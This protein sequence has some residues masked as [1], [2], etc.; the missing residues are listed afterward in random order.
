MPEQHGRSGQPD[1]G[2]SRDFWDK[3][4]A[5]A[6]LAAGVLVA[7]IGGLFTYVYNERA[8]SSQ[9]A[10]RER[11]LNVQH[12]RTV[13]TL[14]PHLSSSD[15]REKEFALVAIS[16]LGNGS[17]AVKLGN[18]YRDEASVGAL[19]KIATGGDQAAARA[20]RRSLSDIL[21][22]MRR[23]VVEVEYGTSRASG[24]I[25]GDGTVVTVG[26]AV[27]DGDEV[28]LTFVDGETEDAAVIRG[29]REFGVVLVQ[30]RGSGRNALP[31]K[32][33]ADVGP[34][35]DV[36]LLGRGRKDWVDSSGT[37]TGVTRSDGEQLL[38]ADIRTEP[39]V[40][41]APVVSRAG[42]V[43]AIHL[44]ADRRGKLLLPASAIA[45]AVARLAGT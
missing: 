29:S 4:Q 2:G 40:A 19:E 3:A 12:V 39:G 23:A 11:A 33:G 31:I 7:V 18:I 5:V 1:A 44:G 9:E 41:G 16:A 30:S 10:Q 24:F 27:S 37:I 26:S 8:R 36:V 17:L 38:V 21:A 34:G 25:A 20:A 35:V 22:A 13:K 14:F 43:V 42:Q 15:P 28:K 45:R 6:G 32:A